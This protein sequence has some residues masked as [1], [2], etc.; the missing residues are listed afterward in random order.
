MRACFE[1]SRAG[2]KTR[3]SLRWDSMFFSMGAREASN[4]RQTAQRK[5]PGRDE[6]AGRLPNDSSGEISRRSAAAR[7]DNP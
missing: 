3:D 2:L 1:K 4:G 6:A 5:L 7:D